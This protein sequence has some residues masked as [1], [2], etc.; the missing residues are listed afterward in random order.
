MDTT[1]TSTSD[2]EIETYPQ[3]DRVIVG[4]ALFQE[5]CW[6]WIE[7]KG[8]NLLKAILRENESKKPR[9]TRNNADWIK[10]EKK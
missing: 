1:S 3:D 2:I 9:L 5:L 8:P 10:T 7:T 4:E 6:A